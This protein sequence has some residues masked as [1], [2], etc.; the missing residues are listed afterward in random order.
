MRISSI[1]PQGEGREEESDAKWRRGSF[2]APLECVF[3]SDSEAIFEIL[4]ILRRLYTFIKAA[5]G[6]KL[7]DTVPISLVSKKAVVT[8]GAKAS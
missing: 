1:T 6:V 2:G 8:Y 7:G 5:H 4:P 3:L